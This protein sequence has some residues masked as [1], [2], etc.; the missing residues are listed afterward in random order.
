MDMDMVGPVCSWVNIRVCEVFYLGQGLFQ[1]L[2]CVQFGNIV[3][4]F[5][6]RN[7]GVAGAPMPD[8]VDKLFE[9]FEEFCDGFDKVK[10]FLR[11]SLVG[12][13]L[14]GVCRI[15]ENVP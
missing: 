5:V 8:Y 9:G 15:S 3:D 2:C 13:G 12:K 11:V 7:V 6:F 10:V 14:D 4:I 1:A